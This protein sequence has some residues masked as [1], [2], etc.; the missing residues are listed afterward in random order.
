MHTSST[1][2]YSQEPESGFL[3]NYFT[4]F[5]KFWF[6]P[7]GLLMTLAF[8]Y[9]NAM[10]MLGVPKQAY[11]IYLGVTIGIMLF[12]EW[13]MPA[14][15]D[16]S[17]SR[18]SFLRRDVPMLLLNGA[19]LAAT[20]FCLTALTVW[21]A[22]PKVH[23]ANGLPWWVQ[24]CVAILISDFLWYWV[25]R[26]SHQARGRL[27]QWMWK[28]HVAHHLPQQV[29]VFMHAVGHPIN[30]AYVRVIL[31][32]PPVF[33]GF[34]EEA[35]FAAAVLTGFQGLVSHFNVDVRAGYLNYL[36][37]GT[38]LHRYHHSSA[39]NEGKNYAAVVTIWDQLF[40]SF[41]YHAGFLPDTLGVHDP[42][43]YPEDEQLLRVMAIP[44]K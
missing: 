25:H 39:V 18:R 26:Y 2:G 43:A 34:S 6:Y 20:S 14:R 31:M 11:I 15:A 12:L 44:F 24:A 27:G 8:I 42:D 1:K 40:G 4:R 7:L 13:V 3:R 5:I 21:S 28:T 30:S 16:W 19:A 22:L 10:K 37:M 32:L 29:Y 41:D 9:M 36:F 23:D 17:M 33:L 35:I 38:E